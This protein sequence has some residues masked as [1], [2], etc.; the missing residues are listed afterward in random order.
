MDTAREPRAG[1]ER[2]SQHATLREHLGESYLVSVDEEKHDG[3]NLQEE[4]EQEEDEELRR[5]GGKRLLC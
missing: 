3:Q 4:D 5:Q 1:G 2:E